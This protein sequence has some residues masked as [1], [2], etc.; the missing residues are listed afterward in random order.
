MS[1]KPLLL[2]A[3]LG[4]VTACSSTLDLVPGVSRPVQPVSDAAKAFTV[5]KEI[6]WRDGF[7]PTRSVL[8]RPGDYLLEAEDADYWYFHSPR[9]VEITEK[10]EMM[11]D[12]RSSRYGLPGGLML[13]KRF[14]P[15]P[16]GAYLDEPSG[17]K[18]LILEFGGDFRTMEGTHWRKEF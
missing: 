9:P 10:E 15:V 4:L 5:L 1:A 12:R 6:D 16:G 2:A 13:A 18:R 7:P 17:G 11:R 8:L 14:N 3:W